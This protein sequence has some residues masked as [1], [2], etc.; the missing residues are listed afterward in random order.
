[1][2][3]DDEIKEE[4]KEEK[5][6]EKE[7]EKL[8]LGLVGAGLLAAATA[9]GVSKLNEKSP[10]V[11]VKKNYADLSSDVNSIPIIEIDDRGNGIV[12]MA[13]EMPMEPPIPNAPMEPPVM[14]EPQQPPEPVQQIE[15]V[16]YPTGGGGSSS[17]GGGYY[18]QEQPSQPTQPSEP[19][20]PTKEEPTSEVVPE[21]PEPSFDLVIS[22]DEVK[23]IISKLKTASKN[24]EDYWIAII[25]TEFTKLKESWAGPDM[26]DY[27]SKVEALDPKV[28]K[29]I[30]AVKLLMDTYKK[31]LEKYEE[32]V[33][34]IAAA[35]KE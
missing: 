2:P 19:V 10:D 8:A 1:M 26:E 23:N 15:P 9:V 16:D 32:Q 5:E 3:T 25:D 4:I 24:L 17:G 20:E 7:G 34:K 33:K 27:I 30:E 28:D 11:R 14:N 13:A 6:E 35:I 22:V 29:A 31:A 21:D 18:P 12:N